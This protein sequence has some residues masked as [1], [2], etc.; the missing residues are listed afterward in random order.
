MDG[1][2]SNSGTGWGRS[3]P[4]DDNEML[5]LSLLPDYV[6]LGRAYW[7]SLNKIHLT[8]RAILEFKI[9]VE[10]F[11]ELKEHA[12]EE[13]PEIEVPTVKGR[14]ATELKAFARR[15][16]PDLSSFRGL[17]L[18]VCEPF[19]LSISVKITNNARF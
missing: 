2:A 15:G 17:A 16:G 6:D 12:G 19:P 9:R 8:P 1:Q 4:D 3:V 5:A 7:D 10:T 11:R 14:M 18:R 13:I